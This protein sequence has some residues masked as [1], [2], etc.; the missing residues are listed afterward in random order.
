MKLRIINIMNLVISWGYKST[1]EYFLFLKLNLCCS[2]KYIYF[3]LDQT[4]QYYNTTDFL[5]QKGIFA[6]SWGRIEWNIRCS[7]LYSCPLT[8]NIHSWKYEPLLGWG[9]EKKTKLANFLTN[10]FKTHFNN[11]HEAPMVYINIFIN[12]KIMLTVVHSYCLI[13][14]S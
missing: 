2:S 6:Q 12:K 13:F 5:G 14:F 7:L 10:T 1:S 8:T 11:I 9:M 4:L 3:T